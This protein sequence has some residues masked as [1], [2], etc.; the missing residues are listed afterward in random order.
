[1]ANTAVEPNAKDNLAVAP[2]PPV[3]QPKPPV[4]T[5]REPLSIAANLIAAVGSFLLL[6]IAPTVLLDFASLPDEFTTVLFQVVPMAFADKVLAAF[7]VAICFLVVGIAFQLWQYRRELSSWWPPVLAFPVTG[8]V[9]VP[10]ALA[11]GGPVGGWAIL[12]L[13]L[14]LAFCFHWLTVL[15]AV[16]LME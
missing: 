8:I 15:A 7:A 9:L 1:M 10:D 16:E 11:H 4:P 14:A 13:T 2:Q 5:T 12:A 6:I 3:S